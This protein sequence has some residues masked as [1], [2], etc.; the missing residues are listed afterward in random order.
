MN[1]TNDQPQ[2]WAGFID[3]T[4]WDRA[5]PSSIIQES[6]NQIA[7][8]HPSL[9]C[10]LKNGGWK[11]SFLLGRPIFRGYVKLR[12]GTCWLLSGIYPWHFFFVKAVATKRK[13]IWRSRKLPPRRNA[14]W[15]VSS[16]GG[17]KKVIHHR[18][19]QTTRI[20]SMNFNGEKSRVY[21][22]HYAPCD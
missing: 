22:S 3:S 1:G 17:G 20:N 6:R 11:T 16:V 12:E 8:P 7:S 15:H 10:P 21:H 14:R 9:T 19:C 13:L 18:N 2:R 4:K 5:I